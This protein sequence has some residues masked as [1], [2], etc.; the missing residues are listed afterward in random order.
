MRIVH[1]PGAA[2]VGSTSQAT[3]HRGSSG[4]CQRRA[5]R[6]PGVRAPIEADPQELRRVFTNRRPECGGV[7]SPVH[8][9]LECQRTGTGPLGLLRLH[10]PFQDRDARGILVP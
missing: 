8:V 5:L 1:C 4:L 10:A 2:A 3:L 7:R 9:I 6:H